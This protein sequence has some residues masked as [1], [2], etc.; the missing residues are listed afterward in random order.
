[1]L[2]F[3]GRFFMIGKPEELKDVT[4]E[5]A[6]YYSGVGIITSVV[7]RRDGRITL[8]IRRTDANED[9]FVRTMKEL[10]TKH[11]VTGFQDWKEWTGD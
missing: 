7:T 5:I 8:N 11:G 3:E 10:A 4:C 1:M 6:W 2:N 9:Y